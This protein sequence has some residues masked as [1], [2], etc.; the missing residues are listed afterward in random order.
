MLVHLTSIAE[1]PFDHFLVGCYEDVSNPWGYII[2]TP[3][4]HS[5]LSSILYSIEMYWTLFF[6][7]SHFK[8]PRKKTI[9]NEDNLTHLDPVRL[10]NGSRVLRLGDPSW[11]TLG[12]SL[13]RDSGPAPAPWVP[14][15]RG[16]QL[17]GSPWQAIAIA[18]YDQKMAGEI[19]IRVDKSLV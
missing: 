19:N 3:K 17:R 9:L 18:W 10:G 4:S 13:R 1:I 11:A 5:N 15:A 2:Y 8:K 16:S 7:S 12:W 6:W 14:L